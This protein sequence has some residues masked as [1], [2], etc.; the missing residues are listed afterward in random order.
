MSL[1]AEATSPDGGA[2]DR[3]LTVPNVV[4]AV[5]ILLLPVFVWL[6]FEQ[7]DR[8]AAAWL[9]AFLGVTDWVDGW[10]AR[11][12]H[13]VST[14]GKILDPT[15][16]RL[17]FL[18]GVVAIVVDGSVPVW[19]AA[20]TLGREVAVAAVV[21][22]LAA[23]GARRIDVTFVGKTATFLLLVAFPAFLMSH[24]SVSWTDVAG[25]IAW[26][27][28]LPGLVLSYLAAARYVPA[29]RGALRDG[30]RDRGR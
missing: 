16:D 28:V 8:T 7:E 25:A 27:S 2:G 3:I 17:V 9:L 22:A 1:A 14:V 26:V 18:V 29:A 15:A 13:Q 21:L 10:F 5:R 11:R 12:F 24:A 23:A 30:R 4:S 20:L 6:L 19:V